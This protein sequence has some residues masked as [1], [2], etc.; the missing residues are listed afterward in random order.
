MTPF[1]S[2]FG[3]YLPYARPTFMPTPGVPM[4]LP[5]LPVSAASPNRRPAPLE[6][7]GVIFPSDMYPEGVAPWAPG[8]QEQSLEQLIKMRNAGNWMRSNL[9]GMWGIPPLG[10]MGAVGGAGARQAQSQINTRAQSDYA[11]RYGGMGLGGNVYSGRG[12]TDQNRGGAASK[13]SASPKS[14]AKRK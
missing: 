12:Y 14:E 9:G 7:T 4:G 2:L 6:Q 13:R 8:G 3:G 11:R 1:T 5:P 10:L